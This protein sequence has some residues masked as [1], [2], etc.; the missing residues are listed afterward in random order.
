MKRFLTLFVTVVALVSLAACN[1]KGAV[2]VAGITLA[3]QDTEV[4]LG[5]KFTTEGLVVTVKYTDDSTAD[6]TDKAVILENVDENTAG[7]YLVAVLYEG[8]YATYEV[9]VIAPVEIEYD[10]VAEAVEGALA[11]A[12]KVSQGTATLINNN[13]PESFDY[14]FGQNNIKVINGSTARHYELLEDGS[15]FG[16]EVNTWGEESYPSISYDTAPELVNGVDFR[17]ILNYNENYDGFGVDGLVEALYLMATEEGRNVVETVNGDP[18]KYEFSF[19]VPFVDAGVYYYITV[20]FNLDTANGNITSAGVNMYGYSFGTGAEGEDSKDMTYDAENDTYTLNEYIYEYSYIKVFE[21]T[22]E[23]GE[24]V[25]ESEYKASEIL[26]QDFNLVDANGAAI[27][28]GGEVTIAL[29]VPTTVKVEGIVPTTANSELDPINVTITDE[30]GGMIWTLFGSYYDGA[31]ELTG[32]ATGKYCVTVSTKQVTKQFVVVVDYAA[33]TEI[34]AVD[35]NE[36][37]IDEL[38]VYENVATT[39]N[40]AVNSGAQNGATAALKEASDNA[41]VEV[42]DGEIVFTATAAGT[43]V[44]VLTSTANPQVS[45]ELTITVEKTPEM[46]DILNGKFVDTS[47]YD[48]V[49]ITFTPESE[50]ALTGAFTYVDKGY[51]EEYEG[52]YEW[53]ED[54]KELVITAEGWNY[55]LSVTETFGLLLD[56]GWFQL[57]FVKDSTPAGVTETVYNGTW[58]NKMGTGTPVTL[59]LKTD[60]TGSIDVNYGFWVGTFN[61]V[62]VDGTITVSNLT[63][64]YGELSNLTLV[65]I[66]G[67]YYLSITIA[68]NGTL[69]LDVL[70]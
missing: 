39:V 45:S 33:V 12:E 6:V 20:G 63:D 68:D 51:G 65:A 69:E 60:E 25:Q 67:G 24:R 46:K 4:A 61:W 37:K 59:T 66:E 52:T 57:D 27:E 11:D 29:Q 15:L 35:N 44:V 14:Y 54:T 28:E 49:V 10:T 62:D 8:A 41:K 43:Y 21:A 16:V 5:E 7:K 42:V 40:T 1:K 13:S 19:E 30:N 34:Y 31:I 56:M 32:Y 64:E 26:Y 48:D 70:E 55:D 3:G 53:K 22:Q 36:S 50:G 9:A 18:Y 2:N 23:A 58:Y 47:E 17:G 38:S